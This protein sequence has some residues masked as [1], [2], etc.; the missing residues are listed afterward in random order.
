MFS[1]KDIVAIRFNNVCQKRDSFVFVY[2]FH[3]L[4]Y[5][6]VEK[7][8]SSNSLKNLLIFTENEQIPTIVR[9]DANHITPQYMQ[10]L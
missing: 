6:E 4:E 7:A 3:F 10:I 9:T 2:I 1:D 8:A 5:M